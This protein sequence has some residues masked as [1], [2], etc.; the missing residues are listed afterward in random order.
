M[1]H[2]TPVASLMAPSVAGGRPAP[3]ASTENGPPAGVVKDHR[4]EPAH[5]IGPE[6]AG[7]AGR[8]LE[9]DDPGNLRGERVPGGRPRPRFDPRERPDRAGG[10]LPDPGM[11]AGQGA[12]PAPPRGPSR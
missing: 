2:G 3:S 1:P 6:Q 11:R 12:A 7:G 4:S 8:A 10:A 9:P 5:L